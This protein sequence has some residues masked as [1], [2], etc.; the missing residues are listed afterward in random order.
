MLYTVT[1]A[2]RPGRSDQANIPGVYDEIDIVRAKTKVIDSRLEVE[3]TV[4][5]IELSADGRHLLALTTPA[6]QPAILDRARLLV[7]DAMSGHVLT[8]TLLSDL[9]L[10]APGTSVLRLPADAPVEARAAISNTL[11][12][13][14]G[15][16]M[17]LTPDGSSLYVL[18]S[19]E[20]Q[21]WKLDLGAREVQDRITIQAR[22][23]GGAL[24]ADGRTLY[25]W[26]TDRGFTLGFPF[27]TTA[28]MVPGDRCPSTYTEPGGA[29]T[30][31]LLAP[32]V[33]IGADGTPITTTLGAVISPTQWGAQITARY[34]T[35]FDPRAR[36]S[37]QGVV[38]N[39]NTD[40]AAQQP[41]ML[42][43]IQTKGDVTRSRQ[44]LPPGT[45][46]LATSPVNSDLYV[47]NG[48][49]GSLSIVPPDGAPTVIAVGRDPVALV[50]SA[51]GK[52]AYVANRESR[53]IS[54]IYLPVAA[55]IETISL[56]GEPFSLALR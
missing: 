18:H 12:P 16:Q 42:L 55:V 47:L 11:F 15:A 40:T 35:Y 36:A 38:V 8:D 7:L 56:D 32:S 28:L 50:V 19:N 4:Q 43:T 49:L 22:P 39:D 41:D 5:D 25:V 26:A 54:A 9:D 33:L 48:P 44:D 23:H 29:I 3:G 52:W 45:S 53:T 31:T 46:A 20:P 21:V 37:G 2:E 51:D 14:A 17:V 1:S 24:S 13:P 30:Y 34:C 27:P 10:A 6:G